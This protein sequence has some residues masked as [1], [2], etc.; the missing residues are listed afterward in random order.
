V[1]TEQEQ[2]SQVQLYW[3]LAGTRKLSCLVSS[4]APSIQ[5]Q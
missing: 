1:H 5:V 2:D 4:T 3:K